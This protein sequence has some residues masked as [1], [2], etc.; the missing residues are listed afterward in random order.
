[1]SSKKRKHEN[2]EYQES[3][4]KHKKKKARFDDEEMD[5]SQGKRDIQI[6]IDLFFP[7]CKVFVYI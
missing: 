4:G 2:E 6:V 5:A 1:M 7:C 3:R